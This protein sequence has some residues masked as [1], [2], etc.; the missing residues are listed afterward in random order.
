MLDAH[1][2]RTQLTACAARLCK[3]L[4]GIDDG[5]VGPE[6]KRM[7]RLAI[8]QRHRTRIGPRWSPSEYVRTAAW[9]IVEPNPIDKRMV[10]QLVWERG[11][12][13]VRL[14]QCWRIWRI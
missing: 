4:L 14:R 12:V 5:E 10:W 9:D 13:P 8:E 1:Y 6:W 11:G 7:V 2:T 3:I